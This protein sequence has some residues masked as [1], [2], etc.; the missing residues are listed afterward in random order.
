MAKSPRDTAGKASDRRDAAT[1]KPRSRRQSATTGH[2]IE[3]YSKVYAVDS[4][5]IQR[6]VA[7]GLLM[8]VRDLLLRELD[9]VLSKFGTSFARYHVLAIIC[10]EG[11]GIQLTE[12][13]TLAGVHPTTLT[14]TIDR[15]V[16]DGFIERRRDPVDRRGVF[17]VGTRKGY[18][19]YR[20][21]R[22]ELAAIQYGL[23]DIDLASVKRLTEDLDKI[24]ELIERR[25][26]D[27]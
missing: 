21:A 9:E 26:A 20:E 16:R 24:A 22:A 3:S 6:I 27:Q 13:A 4:D 14:A 1:R 23:A 12:I 5:A 7:A 2:L 10:R 25:N 19:Q 17:A 11:E 18:E 8:R 15:L